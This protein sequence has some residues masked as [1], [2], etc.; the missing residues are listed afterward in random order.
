MN[1][2]LLVASAVLG[3]GLAGFFAY[4]WYVVDDKR[5]AEWSDKI[6]AELESARLK[7]ELRAKDA[8]MEQS[9]IRIAELLAERDT[10][11]KLKRKP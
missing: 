2:Y 5:K 7:E 11:R 8:T 1:Q 4:L 9:Q 3:L 10:L 6:N